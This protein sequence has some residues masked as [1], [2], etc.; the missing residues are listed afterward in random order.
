MDKLEKVERLRN[1]AN[2]SYEEASA[3]LDACGQDLLDAIVML[4]RQGKT[5][6]PAQSTYSTDYEAQD[7]YINVSDRVEQQKQ[8]AP[9]FQKSVAKF[10]RTVVRFVRSTNFRITRKGSLLFEFS[11]WIMVILL[12]FFWKAA[13][14]IAI[15]AWFF[16]C[17]YSFKDVGDRQPQKKGDKDEHTD[18]DR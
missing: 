3:A 11:S 17:R 13:L 18:P 4:E 2:V 6:E 8:D 16:G 7:D 10:F 9:T 5:V 15:I 12:L 14:P 1:Y